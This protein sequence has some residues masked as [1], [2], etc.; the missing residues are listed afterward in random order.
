MGK[1]PAELKQ[2]TL[3]CSNVRVENR[4]F[5][6]LGRSHTSISTGNKTIGSFQIDKKSD[7]TGGDILKILA[8]DKKKIKSVMY[9]LVP[10]NDQ[11]WN[12]LGHRNVSSHNFSHT[13]PVH[14]WLQ[15][16]SDSFCHPFTRHRRRYTAILIIIQT[17]LRKTDTFYLFKQGSETMLI[18]KYILPLKAVCHRKKKTTK[19]TALTRFALV[20]A[21]MLTLPVPASCL[22]LP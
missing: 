2:F 20:D 5:I 9:M 3:K 11:V 13:R 22:I 12:W 8:T 17:N 14:L 10:L 7:V 4:N 19:N 21:E 15:K 16:S 6:I 1:K 18:Q